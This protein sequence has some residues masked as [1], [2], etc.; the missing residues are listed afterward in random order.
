M[1]L[2]PEQFDKLVTKDEFHELKKQVEETN[3]NVKKVLTVVD[4][5]AKKHQTFE[6]ELAS[7]QG[8]HDRVS[9]T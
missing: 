7:N 4:G 3:V 5:I 8:A 6:V 2:T 1:K 9:E